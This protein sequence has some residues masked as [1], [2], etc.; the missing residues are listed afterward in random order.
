MTFTGS[1]IDFIQQIADALEKTVSNTLKK[2]TKCNNQYT[3]NS[4]SYLV[5]KKPYVNLQIG[6][7]LSGA[8]STRTDINKCTATVRS[9]TFTK[10][11][12]KFVPN[13]K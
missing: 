4:V 9:L 8:R 1:T 6:R 7:N 5:Y 3:A 11:Y 10:E 12:K 2:Q 13:P